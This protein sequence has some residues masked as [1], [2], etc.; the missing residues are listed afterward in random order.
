M[1]TPNS[2]GETSKSP[3]A[4]EASRAAVAGFQ[5]MAVSSI[6]QSGDIGL[7]VRLFEELPMEFRSVHG[8]ERLRPQLLNGMCVA[9]VVGYDDGGGE[10]ILGRPSDGSGPLAIGVV[11][12]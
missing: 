5:H 11:A 1:P 7:L 12:L 9:C 3:R 2:M 4:R 10:R 8:M 6:T